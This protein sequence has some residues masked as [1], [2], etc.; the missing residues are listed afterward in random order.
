MAGQDTDL[1]DVEC[2][3]D[4]ELGCV[5]AASTD[6]DDEGGS[7]FFDF[8]QDSLEY[9]AQSQGCRIGYDT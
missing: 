4:E 3:Q 8:L 9:W 2:W 6:A 1:R 5:L 7:I